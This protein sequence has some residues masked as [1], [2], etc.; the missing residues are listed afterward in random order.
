MTPNY[1]EEKKYTGLQRGV[2]ALLATV[3]D[4]LVRS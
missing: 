4:G 1:R 3:C 2:V